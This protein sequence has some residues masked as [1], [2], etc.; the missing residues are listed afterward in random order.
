MTTNRVDPLEQTSPNTPT[1]KREKAKIYGKKLV[2]SA[3][4]GAKTLSN[5]YKVTI[6]TI[7]VV[8]PGSDF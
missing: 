1:S 3:K 5:A 2:D 8:G 4:I 6:G 7:E